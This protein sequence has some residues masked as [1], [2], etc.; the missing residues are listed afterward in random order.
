MVN[1]VI[2]RMDKY[3]LMVGNFKIMSAKLL[4]VIL[5]ANHVIVVIVFVKKVIF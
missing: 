2:V 4:S 5:H 1:H 3:V